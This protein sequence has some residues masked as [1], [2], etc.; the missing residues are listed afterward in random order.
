[1]TSSP[2]FSHVVFMTRRFEEMKAW[3]MNVFGAEIVHGDAALAFLTYDDESHRFAIAN[4]D[5]LKPDAPAD[6]GHGEI[7]LNHIAY[8]YPT[9]ADLL[10]TYAR[11]RKQGV[12]PYW[13]VHHGF[14]LSMYYQ[15]PDGNRIELQVES[16][17]S[18]EAFDYMRSNAFA[19]NPVGVEFDP[20]DL[21]ARYREGA[22]EAELTAFPA[23][24][25]SAIPEAH[26]IA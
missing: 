16:C 20:E 10:E 3:Y 15:D 25:P 12:T 14:T 13:P 9:A 5:I 23:G 26:G 7:G 1:M 6:S 11:L 17:N 8:T 22:S 24:S 19:S 2:T 21:L 18:Q 4:L